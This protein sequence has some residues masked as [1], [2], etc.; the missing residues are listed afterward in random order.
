[1]EIVDL[2]VQTGTIQEAAAFMLIE[3]FDEPGGW[4][5]LLVARRELARIMD[6]GFAH[7]M[8]D[9][10]IVAGWVGGLPE[11][12]GRV[13]ELHP[14]VVHRAYRNRGI[15]RK[16]VAH[17]E[18]EA[19]VRGALTVTLG[20]DDEAG[21][22]SLSQVDLYSDFPRHLKEIRDLGRRHPFL[23][24]RKL[25][26]VVTGVVPDANGLGRPDIIMSK[27]VVPTK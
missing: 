7:A 1:M 27:R 4:P 19:S 9:D 12:H 22:T 26:Y 13:W 21:M 24:Y 2:S 3:Q 18:V 23:F 16:L 17:F 8:L 5:D 15:G 6:E 10:S 25:G 20:T 14:V 11:Y